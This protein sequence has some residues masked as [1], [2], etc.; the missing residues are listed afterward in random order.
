M[1]ISNTSQM[2]RRLVMSA[3]KHLAAAKTCMTNDTDW[4]AIHKH[5]GFANDVTQLWMLGFWPEQIATFIDVSLP[6]KVVLMV[7]RRHL[8]INQEKLIQSIMDL[9]RGPRITNPQPHV[10]PGA[11]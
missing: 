10:Q 8:A 6:E 7:L 4:P 1:S 11:I 2:K 3:R 5:R 9:A